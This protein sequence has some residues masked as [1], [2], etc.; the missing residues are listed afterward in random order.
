MLYSISM[1]QLSLISKV[2][3]M[4]LGNPALVSASKTWGDYFFRAAWLHAIWLTCWKGCWLSMK[5]DLLCP[6]WYDFPWLIHIDTWLG[7]YTVLPNAEVMA[8]NYYKQLEELPRKKYSMSS[9]RKMKQR[10]QVSP[11]CVLFLRLERLFN[12]HWRQRCSQGGPLPYISWS[13]QKD[14]NHLLQT[15]IFM[16]FHGFSWILH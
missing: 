16:D 14:S 13:S 4:K 8:I 9:G 3:G 12:L 1:Y 10:I 11:A 5:S 2:K 15:V 7:F 6:I